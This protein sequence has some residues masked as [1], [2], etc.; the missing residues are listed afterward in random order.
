MTTQELL[1]AVENIRPIL[2]ADADKAEAQRMPTA[3]MCQAMYS[4]GLYS[5][6]APRRYGGLEMHPTE[7]MTVWEAVARIDSGAAWNLVMTRASPTTRRGCQR[8]AL[9]SC[10]QMV[11]PP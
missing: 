6:L 2:I 4:A 10:S 3:A 9:K 11:S 7:C 8:Q 1:N 5:M